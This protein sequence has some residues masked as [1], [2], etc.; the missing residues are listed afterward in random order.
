MIMLAK[1]S[2]EL[3]QR[4]LLEDLR[5]MIASPCDYWCVETSDYEV[6]III[7][8]E[9]STATM[10]S[11]LARVSAATASQIES[12]TSDWSDSEAFLA[13]E[14][15]CLWAKSV[16]TGNI[17]AEL[18]AQH[19]GK[20]CELAEDWLAESNEELPPLKF[21]TPISDRLQPRE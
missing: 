2:T 10:L 9:D 17:S 8:R 11:P 7:D 4:R 12:V 19:L 3:N 18:L 1:S 15:R 16:C 21:E 13:I 6:M 20:I 14:G 5:M